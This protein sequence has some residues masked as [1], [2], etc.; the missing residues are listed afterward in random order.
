MLLCIPRINSANNL[1]AG[2]RG[3]GRIRLLLV[4]HVDTVY[5]QGAVEAQPFSIRDDLAFGPG[6]I[7]MKSGVLM[8]MY[9]LRVLQEAGFEEYG[10]LCVVFNNDEEVGSPGS[11]PLLRKIAQ[12]VNHYYPGLPILEMCFNSPEIPGADFVLSDSP[13]DLLTAIKLVLAGRRVRGYAE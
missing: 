12:Q 11:I 3:K 10:E 5:A 2:C 8:G 9:A 1:V 4:G 6:V 7:D 13:A